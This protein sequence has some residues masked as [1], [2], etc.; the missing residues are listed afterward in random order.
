MR[1]AILASLALHA[2]AGGWALWPA[3]APPP[4]EAMVVEL[5]LVAPPPPAPA[6]AI[7]P[8]SPRPARARPPATRPRPAAE[9]APAPPEPAVAG[10]VE[11]DAAATGEASSAVTIPTAAGPSRDASYRM[12]AAD[13][14]LPEYPWSARRRGREGRVVIAM[15]VAADGVPG[16]LAVVESSGDAAL[17]RAALETLARWRLD[18][19]LRD[20]VRVAGRLSIPIRFRLDGVTI[21]A[22]R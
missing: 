14:P 7:T 18:P 8:P 9:P 2:A 13:T 15:E 21:V 20:G 3:A 22:A 4:A 6:I 19:A 12:G 10:P 16:E 17:D 1:K 5:S 11:A